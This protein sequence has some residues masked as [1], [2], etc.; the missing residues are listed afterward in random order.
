[1]HHGAIAAICYVVRMRGQKDSFRIIHSIKAAGMN[2][3]LTHM[4][5][6]QKLNDEE[7][8]NETTGYLSP[9]SPAATRVRTINIYSDGM[10]T[11]CAVL[12]DCHICNE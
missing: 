3:K 12:S 5:F 11:C 10:R 7:R 2:S 8:R 9:L 6:I 4:R 1:M